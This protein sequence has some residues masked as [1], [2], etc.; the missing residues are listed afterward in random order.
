M[1]KL[2]GNEWKKGVS[3]AMTVLLVGSSIQIPVEAKEAESWI[4]KNALSVVEKLE[5]ETRTVEAELSSQDRGQLAKEETVYVIANAEG[6]PEKLIVS[7]WLKNAMGSEKLE[8]VTELTNITNVKGTEGFEQREGTLGVW[9]AAGNDIY[10]QGNIEKE[11]PVDLKVSYRLNGSAIS[12]EELAGKSGSVSIRFDYTNRQKETVP[13]GEKE[14][15]LYVPFVV[16]TS[17]VL[18][19]ESFRNIE[20]SSGKVINDGERS[21][22]VGYAMPGL[23]ENLDIDSEDFDVEEL[24]I[25]EYVEVTADVTDFSLATTL[26]VATNEIFA[27]MDFDTQEKME[28]LSADMDELQDAMQELMDGTGEL[29]DG[30]LELYDGTEE[31]YDGTGELTDGIDELYDGARKLNEGAGELKDGTNEL[32][33]GIGTLKTGAGSLFAGVKQL[34][35]GLKQITDNDKA[36]NDGTKALYE[37]VFQMANAQLAALNQV[38]IPVSQL[39]QPKTPEE[40]AGFLKAIQENQ[41]VIQGLL[42]NPAMVKDM[43]SAAVGATPTVDT[44]MISQQ[45]AEKEEAPASEPE[46]EAEIGKEAPVEHAKEGAEVK[47]QVAEKE[48]EEEVSQE[49][50]A[51]TASESPASVPETKEVQEEASQDTAEALTGNAEEQVEE[52]AAL[53]PESKQE[54]AEETVPEAKGQ[55]EALEEEVPQAEVQEV[56]AVMVQASPGAADPMQ[57]I[58]ALKEQMIAKTVEQLMQTLTMTQG[59]LELLKGAYQVYAGVGS[60]TQGV[61]QVYAGV[62]E[63]L[64][65]APALNTGMDALDEGAGKLRDGA[66]ELKDGTGELYD[67]TGE[68]QDGGQELRDGVEE[69]R[70]GVV[71]LRDGS[72]ELKDGTIEFNEEGIQKLVDM[73]DGDLQEFSDRFEGVKSAAKAYR[74]FAGISDGVDGSVRFVYKTAGVEID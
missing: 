21:I 42:D 51:P 70:D 55:D 5:P 2:V 29:F 49:E 9:D 6:S 50:A 31:L 26:T 43:V 18:D 72:E 30:V 22:L 35:D 14:E 58:G 47:K 67:G 32:Y 45:A 44:A 56:E 62:Q 12:P 59:T 27:D 74:S 68:L 20:I 17:M 46:E 63:L 71:E 15:E 3:V 34:S 1:K 36:L 25:P 53:E 23:K 40:A 41:A 19:N 16:M 4:Q 39:T 60:Y 54:V 8:D 73:L 52:P 65:N 33:N 66:K 24:D 57:I 61:D 28:D 48:N 64:K 11:L 38:G 10:Y 37:G 7:D 69:L 13:V